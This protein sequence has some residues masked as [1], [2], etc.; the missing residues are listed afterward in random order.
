MSILGTMGTDHDD[1]GFG[2]GKERELKD[3][4]F[5]SV[6]EANE[7]RVSSQAPMPIPRVGVESGFLACFGRFSCTGIVS[8]MESIQN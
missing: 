2:I 4:N 8:R 6:K 7:A 3:R 1:R 5:Y